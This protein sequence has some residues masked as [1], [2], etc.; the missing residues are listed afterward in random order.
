MGDAAHVITPFTGTGVNLAMHDAYDLGVALEKV[1]FEGAAIDDILDAYESRIL[2]RAA[3]DS[4]KC[5]A[6]QKVTLDSGNSAQEIV[7]HMMKTF[8]AK[9]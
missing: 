3:V 6:N 5:S 8:A 7:N 2:E 1:A 4:D 9:T